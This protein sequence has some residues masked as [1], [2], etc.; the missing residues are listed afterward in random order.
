MLFRSMRRIFLT[1][2]GGPFRGYSAD[3]LKDITVAQALKH[4]TWSM[5]NKITVDSATLMNKGL[6]VIEACWLFGCSPKQ[7]EVVV[8]PQSI[9]HSMV[10]FRDGSVMAQMGFP[11]IKVPIQLAL[12]W[13]DRVINSNMVFDPFDDRTNHLTFE[14]PDTETFK[15]LALAYQAAEIGGTLPTVLNAAN[16]EAVNLFLHGKLSFPAIAERVEM[17]MKL[18]TSDNSMGKIDLSGLLSI[19][20]W[21]RDQVLNSVT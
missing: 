7:I 18:H 14:R 5:G 1:A 21:A 4:P 17:V 6:E 11:D 13:P 2:S 10:E 15:L 19:D 20:R 12:T 16:E 8:H 3:Q 9:I